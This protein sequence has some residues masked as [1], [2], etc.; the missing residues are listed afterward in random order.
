VSTAKV[1]EYRKNWEK[2]MRRP[3]KAPREILST[4]H[5]FCEGIL[6]FPVRFPWQVDALTPFPEATGTASSNWSG[7][8]G[9]SRSVGT[10]MNSLWDQVGCHAN[11]D[12]ITSQ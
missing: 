8:P 6:G 11:H 7:G 1:R 9:G 5:S 10:E 4:P 2:R 12:D 3:K